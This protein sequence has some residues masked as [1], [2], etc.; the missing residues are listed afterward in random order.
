MIRRAF[1]RRR[2]MTFVEVII[3]ATIGVVVSGATAFLVLEMAKEQKKGLVD[4]ELNAETS[5]V[6]DRVERVLRSMSKTDSVAFGDAT[7][8]ADGSTAYRRVVLSSGIGNP[9]EELFYDTGAHTLTHDPDRDV[10]GNEI[11]LAKSANLAILRDAYFMPSM[12]TGGIPDNA[13]LNVYL[14]F[15]DDG[16]SGRKVWSASDHQYNPKVTRVV[17]SFTVSFRNY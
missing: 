10:S 15:D 7:T 8:L 4:T 12:K 1:Q 11:V 9:R 5:K 17:R 2:G 14:E 6:Q 13:V 3:A 16:K